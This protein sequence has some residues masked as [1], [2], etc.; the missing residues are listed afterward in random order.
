MADSA[1]ATDA[2]QWMARQIASRGYLSQ[3]DAVYYIE[4]LFGEQF[5]Y[6]NENGNPAISRSVLKEFRR[7]TEDDV[8]WSRSDFSWTKRRRG[9]APGRQQD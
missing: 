1:T 8:V 4:K 9:D 6:L 7:L 2:A 3:S 5:V